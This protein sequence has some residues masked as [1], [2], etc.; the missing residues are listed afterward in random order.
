MGQP[1]HLAMLAVDEP[2]KEKAQKD[3]WKWGHQPLLY[4]VSIAGSK[5]KFFKFSMLP[6]GF[7]SNFR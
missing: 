4:A 5:E 6:H 7:M 3:A 1:S 2:S